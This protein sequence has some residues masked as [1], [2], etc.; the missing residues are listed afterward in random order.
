MSLSG[1]DHAAALDRGRDFAAALDARR[2]PLTHLFRP[3]S[4]DAD[5]VTW[6]R[7]RLTGGDALA[8]HGYNHDVAPLGRRAV[9]GRRAEFA[10]LPRHEAGLRLTAA[11]RAL[12]AIGLGTAVFVPPRWLASAGTFAAAADQGFRVLADR[13]SVR[14]LSTG[15]LDRAQVM[16]FR[17]TGRS[18][19][20]QTAGEQLRR[21]LLVAEVERVARH[22][23]LVR[24]HVQEDD[25]HLSSR[26]DALLA[27]VDT[28]LSRGALP[29]TYR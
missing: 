8:V 1:L 28:A 21:R 17:T 27:A 7:E 24:I 18:V 6:L 10:G 29:L 19:T 11:R 15:Q 23:G 20:D 12:T 5:L 16:G 3:A 2:V 25:V 22:G 14:D 26:Y 13:H 9:V 4:G